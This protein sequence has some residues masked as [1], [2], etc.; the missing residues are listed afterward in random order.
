VPLAPATSDRLRLAALARDT[1]LSVAGVVALDAGTARTFV[2]AG[3]GEVVRGV[4]CVAAPAGGFDVGLQLVCELVPL[5]P[6][7]DRVRAALEAAA[8]GAALSA[9]S[10]T[11]RVT[12]VVDPHAPDV[13]ERDAV[14]EAIAARADA[15]AQAA[16]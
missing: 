12:D 8:A 5:H 14:R 10:V 16:S 1:A 9:E 7:G 13:A 11:I 15:Q 6:L 2:T 3:A 4:T